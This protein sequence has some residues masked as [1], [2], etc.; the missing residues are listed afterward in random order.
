MWELL[1][2]GIEQLRREAGEHWM[3]ARP[4]IWHLGV[5]RTPPSSSPSWPS[6]NQ[7]L[8]LGFWKP[9]RRRDSFPLV[10]MQIAGLGGLLYMRT[11]DYPCPAGSLELQ[12]AG[13]LGLIW[14]P[15]M[16]QKRLLLCP[17]LPLR[18]RKGQVMLWALP[19]MRC[20]CLWELW[21]DGHGWVP[22]AV[23]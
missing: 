23:C 10:V 17:A 12:A 22:L 18:Q 5:Q 14:E 13:S 21:E 15:G 4:A 6:R 19:G 1:R 11:C 16:W 20:R 7:D 8:S 3:C 2:S 9:F